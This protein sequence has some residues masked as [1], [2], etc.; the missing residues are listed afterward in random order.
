MSLKNILKT[1]R[2][3]F[4]R[5][6]FILIN[7]MLYGTGMIILGN[8]LLDLQISIQE[9]FTVTSKVIVLRSI[10]YFTGAFLG[11]IKT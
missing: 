9:S 2:T 7:L 5:S 4:I 3:E 10:G 1:Q 11:K 8:S 6:V